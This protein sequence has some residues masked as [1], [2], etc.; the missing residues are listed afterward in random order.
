MFSFM[1]SA[2]S[3]AVRTHLPLTN[4]ISNCLISGRR[5][6]L[7]HFTKWAITLTV[8]TIEAYRC[9]QLHTKFY[10]IPLGSFVDM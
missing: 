3:N 8:I 6:L 10:P 4:F 1:F 5:L 7:Y 9:H 2:K